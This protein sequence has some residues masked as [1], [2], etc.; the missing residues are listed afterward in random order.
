MNDVLADRYRIDSEIARGAAGTV[1][2][3]HDLITGE[4]VA[5]KILHADAAADVSVTTAFLDEAEVLA[6]LNHP[7]IV[8][9]RDLIV[10]G[11]VMALVMDLVDGVDLRGRIITSGPLSP[12]LAARITGQVAQALAAV[13]AAGIVHGDVKPG[14]ILVPADGGGVRLVDFGIARRIAD[15]DAPTHG[16][17]DYTAPEI[18]GGH[19][20]S[21]KSDVYGLGLVLF[22]ALCGRNPYRGGGIDEVLARHR[23]SVPVRPNAVPV[24]LWSVIESCLSTRPETRPEPVALASMLRAVD[25]VLSDAPSDT[26]NGPF[27]MRPRTDEPNPKPPAPRPAIATTVLPTVAASTKSSE[28]RTIGNGVLA[29]VAA[30]IVVLAA[31]GVLLFGLS[32]GDSPP[33]AEP[34]LGTEEA[35]DEASD[36]TTTDPSASPS[37]ADGTD[38]DP[39]DNSTEDSETDTDPGDGSDPGDDGSDIPGEDL[40]GSVMPGRS[41]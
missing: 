21:A 32:S 7:G 31:A 23:D 15:P 25:A 30:G 14:N 3:A 9:P 38:V 6:E 12:K 29:G 39:D 2:R 20:S 37:S 8:R 1:H 4:E 18:V 16:T 19:P 5:V 10:T 24:E 17:P 35:T 34:P 27:E 22:E 36:N 41:G 11:S 28:K 40:I 13:H 26:V 33:A